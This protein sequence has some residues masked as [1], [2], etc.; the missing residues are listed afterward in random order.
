MSIVFIWDFFLCC[1]VS[2]LCPTLWPRWLQRTR[3]L[4]PPLCP[5]VCSD[6]SP[7]SWWC[8]LTISSFASLFCLQSSQHRSFPVSQLLAS[9]G[10]SIGCWS[11]N[12][13]ASKEYSGLI[14]LR[15]TDLI[16]QS[17][18]SRVFSST[19]VP[20]HQFCST[21]PS[22]LFDILSR[23]VITFLPRSKCLNFM[24][25]VILEKVKSVTA[26]PFSPPISRAVMDA[27]VVF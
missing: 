16:F 12:K 1:S 19:T 25:A 18:D 15:L 11:S 8:R 24:A 10:Q 3:L 20:K 7:F 9:S 17:G 27:M 13:G 4:C 5:R 23:F 14:P 2:E 22:L 21:Q 6:S 26:S